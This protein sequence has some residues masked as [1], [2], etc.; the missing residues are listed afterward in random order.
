MSLEYNSNCPCPVDKSWRIMIGRP[1]GLK[2]DATVDP[3]CKNNHPFYQLNRLPELNT[4]KVTATV[5]LSMRL[6]VLG[7]AGPPDTA[8]AIEKSAVNMYCTMVIFIAAE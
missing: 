7:K 1:Y 5:L 8:S 6:L 4:S 2:F 3:D